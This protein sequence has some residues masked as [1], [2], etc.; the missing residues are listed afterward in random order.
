MQ[1]EHSTLSI[2]D[3]DLLIRLDQKVDS[4]T[5]SI[6]RIEDNTVNRLTAL[7]NDHVTLKEF[8]D[9]EKR[10]RFVERY[11]WGAIAIIGLINLIGFALIITVFKT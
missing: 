10:L 7:E 11:V 3:H 1:E 2:R 4:V 6:K 9:H 8:G 5:D